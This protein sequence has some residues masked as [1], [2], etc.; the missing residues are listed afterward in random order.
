MTSRSISV[1]NDAKLS[2]SCGTVIDARDGVYAGERLAADAWRLEKVTRLAKIDPSYPT[3]FAQGV[4][5]Y[6]MQRYEESVRAFE[7]WLA[8]HPSGALALR[9]EAHL[10]AARAAQKAL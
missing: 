8:A 7:G 1:M 4:L 3:A 5:Y 9:D 6:R 10:R 2:P